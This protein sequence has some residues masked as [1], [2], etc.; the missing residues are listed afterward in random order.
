MSPVELWRS[1]RFAQSVYVEDWDEVFKPKNLV[2]VESKEEEDYVW[3]MQLV[4]GCEIRIEHFNDAIGLRTYR[5]K[6]SP[7]CV[8]M[9][10]DP[11]DRNRI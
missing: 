8:Y 1:H 9:T 11:S 10:W 2:L 3:A 4:H 6:T 7:G 5:M